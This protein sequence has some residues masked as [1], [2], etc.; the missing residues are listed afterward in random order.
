MDPEQALHQLLP[1][2][3]S[4]NPTSYLQDAK[5]NEN[6]EI[7]SIEFT[8]FKKGNKKHKS[9]ENTVLG[10]I[11]LEKDRLV[12]ETNSEK[13]NNKGKKLLSKYLGKSI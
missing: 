6:G 9:W 13:R 1:L 10:H 5:R 3:L 11:T 2:T 8:W 7:Q 4:K 12:L